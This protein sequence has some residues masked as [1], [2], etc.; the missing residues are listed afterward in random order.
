MKVTINISDKVQEAFLDNLYFDKEVVDNIGPEDVLRVII[1]RFLY[2]KIDRDD[3][4]MVAAS[5]IN[6]IDESGEL[7]DI[8]YEISLGKELPV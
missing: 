5:Y 1:G 8:M 3:I 7:E 2:S 4:D 6:S